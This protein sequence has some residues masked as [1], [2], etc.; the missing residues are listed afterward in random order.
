M[1]GTN[2]KFLFALVPLIGLV[3][4]SGAVKTMTLK[5][6]AKT[7]VTSPAAVNKGLV[8][9]MTPGQ[10]GWERVVFEPGS[11]IP[12]IV[13]TA[14]DGT[15][16][17]KVQFNWWEEVFTGED[18]P[19]FLAVSDAKG[20]YTLMQQIGLDEVSVN[21]EVTMNP[22]PETTVAALWQCPHGV[23]ASPQPACPSGA[24]CSASG[25]MP[26]YQ[27]PAQSVKTD[28]V[29]VQIKATVTAKGIAEPD[30]TKWGEFSTTLLNADSALADKIKALLA[31]KGFTVEATIDSTF[32]SAN[33]A[34]H[35]LPA[36]PVPTAADNNLPTTSS[37]GEGVCSDYVS[38]GGGAI[39]ACS[40]G[41]R[42]WYTCGTSEY[43]CASISNCT[44]AAQ[45]VL[46]A[47]GCIRGGFARSVAPP[48][49]PQLFL[50]SPQGSLAPFSSADYF[51]GRARRTADSCLRDSRG[52]SRRM[53]RR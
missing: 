27:L 11:E 28:E 43:Y 41:E 40:D 44:A 14:A 3:A 22:N 31:E 21:A 18:R 50:T 38:C 39:K 29:A 9:L 45:S 25:G 35:A 15:F 42:S 32:L 36:V 34:V 13:T 10:S 1:K 26:C 8:S 51:I 49:L 4:C 7:G 33:I 20:T 12:N 17:F 47:C 30:P 46:A 5:G 19:V 23:F 52:N 6:T 2:M 53:D 37:G 48:V 16:T 24:V